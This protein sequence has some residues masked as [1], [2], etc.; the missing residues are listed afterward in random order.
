[1]IESTFVPAP[2]A[3]IVP[4]LAA[5]ASPLKRKPQSSP[6]PTSSTPSSPRF[7]AGTARLVGMGTDWEN[8]LGSSG[9]GLNDAYDNA[10]SAVIYSEDSGDD[11]RSLSV[12]E[13][14]DDTDGLL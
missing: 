12:G 13:E 7:S 4:R 14:H 1:M 11:R 9:N 5:R 3:K 8:I 2:A 10:V 6:G